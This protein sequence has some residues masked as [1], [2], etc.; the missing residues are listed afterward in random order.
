[1]LY[2]RSA[3]TDDARFARLVSLGCHDLRTPLATIFGFARMLERTGDLDPQGAGARFLG[4]IIDAS[5]EMGALLDELATAARIEAGR[6]EPGLV[7][8]DTVDLAQSDDERITVT[9]RGETIETEPAAVR[10]ALR[11]FAIAAVRHG[12]VP[13]VRWS[14]DG[15][16]LELGEITPEAAPVVLGEEIRDLAAVV[17]RTVIE[18]LGG[19]LAVTAGRLRVSL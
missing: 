16:T 9:G 13:A 15:R 12:P 17:G 8:A 5:G 7:A 4:M 10:R 11:G 19:S 14:V 6:W 1:M 2:N 18:Q 3:M